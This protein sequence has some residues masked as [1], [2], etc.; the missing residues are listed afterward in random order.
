MRDEVEFAKLIVENSKDILADMMNNQMD[1][2]ALPLN[3]K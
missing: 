3:E 2:E 1:L